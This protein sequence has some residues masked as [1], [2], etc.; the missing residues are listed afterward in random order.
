[1]R[2]T[3]NV[4]YFSAM[5]IIN[6][7]HAY[8]VYSNPKNPNGTHPEQFRRGI[9]NSAISSANILWCILNQ[10][11][12]HMWYLSTSTERELF[13]EIKAKIELLFLT[14]VSVSSPWYF[15][16]D[17]E[18]NGSSQDSE[19][20]AGMSQIFHSYSCYSTIQHSVREI[21]YDIIFHL[22]SSKRN[23]D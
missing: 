2:Q 19:A 23:T 21:P 10:K 14:T 9:T 6:V 13:W 16:N 12:V 5:Q 22:Q 1:M 11:N 4:H 3:Y 17:K 8:T 18:V 7:H 20:T 15:I